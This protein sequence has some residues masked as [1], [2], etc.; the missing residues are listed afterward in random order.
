MASIVNDGSTLKNTLYSSIGLLR[1][2]YIEPSSAPINASINSMM[3]SIL[4]D[5]KLV[6]VVVNYNANI[7]LFITITYNK[8]HLKQTT[9][10][11]Q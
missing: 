2:I 6:T 9:L 3:I 10:N 8:N 11:Y 5:F 7:D 4:N 1:I